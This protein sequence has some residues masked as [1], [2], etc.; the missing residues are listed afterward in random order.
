MLY[1]T[2]ND[3]VSG[4]YNSQVI[5]VVNYLNT[6]SEEKTKLIAFISL[7]KFNEN[8]NKIKSRCPAAK[9]YP[10]FP[11]P[12]NWKWNIIT[13]IIVLFFK[14][15]QKIMSRGVF[16]TNMS[17]YLKKIGLCSKVI[18]DA[19][20]AY[21]A[22]F[23]EYNLI[24]DATVLNSI[25]Q[26]E[27]NAIHLSDYR[28]AVSTKL[29]NYWKTNYNYNSE[30]HQI[31][32]CTLSHD[33]I[34]DLPT[35]GE[36][37]KYKADF[38]YKETDIIFIYSGSSADWQSFSLVDELMCSIMENTNVYL[39]ILSNHFSSEFNVIK[40][41]NDRVKITFVEPQK[42]KHYLLIADYG[43]LYRE[44]S[45]TNQVASPVKFAEYLSCGL[46]ILI[47]NNIGDYSEFVIQHEISCNTNKI[48]KV[49]YSEKLKSHSLS[50]T[51]FYKEC[52]KK[53]YLNIQNC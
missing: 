13:L 7:R 49:S 4:I 44:Q 38:G 33:F 11:K 43:I 24:S 19:R 53:S 18:F 3:T 25:K 9:V 27:Y 29:I 12:K 35:E 32:P 28:L 52:F 23:T 37:K 34:F 2:Y 30:R 41:Y 48:S 47:S 6:I 31:I 51:N 46:S 21:H 16:A 22:E 39:I 45:V 8:K 17:L 26:L 5:D 14:K 20:G 1:L 42:V 10:M 36:L 50:K 15:K 40:K